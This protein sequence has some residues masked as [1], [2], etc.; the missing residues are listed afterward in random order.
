MAT[1]LVDL[2]SRLEE[3]VCTLYHG[4]E[5]KIGEDGSFSDNVKFDSAGV[6]IS[7]AETWAR[8]PSL[9]TFHPL[10]GPSSEMVRF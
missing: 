4:V 8:V 3:I 7:R 1:Q 6:S 9:A 2:F 5:R 10:P